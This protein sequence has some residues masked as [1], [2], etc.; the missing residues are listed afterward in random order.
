MQ[1]RPP[2]LSFD[3]QAKNTALDAGLVWPGLTA[4]V[5][6]ESLSCAANAYEVCYGGDGDTDTAGHRD[7]G[8]NSA[9]PVYPPPHDTADYGDIG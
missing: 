6:V 7:N 3:E 1:P 8:H 5:T 2:T 4:M 9:A